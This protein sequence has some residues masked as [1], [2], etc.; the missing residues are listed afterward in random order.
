MVFWFSVKWRIIASDQVRGFDLDAAY[1]A[2]LRPVWQM[3][4]PYLDALQVKLV[5]TS[6]PIAPAVQEINHRFPGRI[7]TRLRWNDV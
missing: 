4:Y 6:D 2:V 7:P 3:A 5:P 1:R